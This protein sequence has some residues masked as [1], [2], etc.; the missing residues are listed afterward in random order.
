MLGVNRFLDHRGLSNRGFR[1][2]ERWRARRRG[3][4]DT[5]IVVLRIMSGIVTRWVMD[6]DQR[7]VSQFRRR[8]AVKLL[9][10]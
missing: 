8:R 3:N 6:R 2:W 9:C 5:Q 7:I 10:A 1:M 4:G